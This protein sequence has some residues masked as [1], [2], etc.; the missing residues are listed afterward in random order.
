M[1]VHAQEVGQPTWTSNSVTRRGVSWH[2][3]AQTGLHEWVQ[4]VQ[5]I[6]VMARGCG[7]L[8]V[9]TPFTRSDG[10]TARDVERTWVTGGEHPRYMW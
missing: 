9:V 3:C 1:C 4:G 2:P 6:E 10:R 5:C 8:C 7:G